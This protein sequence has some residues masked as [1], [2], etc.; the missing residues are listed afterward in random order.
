METLTYHGGRIDLAMQRFPQAPQ[1]WLDLSTGINAESWRLADALTVDLRAL[2]SVAGL[3]ALCRAAAAAFGAPAVAIAA[4]PGTEIALRMLAAIGLPAPFRHAVPGYRTHGAICAGATGFAIAAIDAVA[5]ERGTVLLANP[6]NPDGRILPPARLLA[7]ARTLARR[8]G[9]LV[10]DEAYADAVPEASVLPHLAAEDPVLVL[11]SFGKFFGLA[12]VRLGFVCGA[13]G[14]VA[15]IAERAGSWPVS[16]TALAYGAAAY[17]DAAW[18]AAMR[19]RIAAAARA[20]DDVLR[21]A[22][23]DP[24]GDCPL[25]RMIR[26]ADAEALFVRLARAGILTRP[27]DDAPDRLRIGLPGDAAALARLAEALRHG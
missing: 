9:V 2:P 12:G 23:H 22:G 26:C 13:A 4:V 27:Y 16:A 17:R 19:A 10:I 6:N 24:V 1:P 7:V 11:R 14:L 25:F 3:D 21:A 5:A 20:L 8:G 18:I 15:R